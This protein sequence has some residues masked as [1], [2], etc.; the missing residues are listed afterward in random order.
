METVRTEPMVAV[1]PVGH[2]L[3]HRR[4]L[5]MDDLAGETLPRR[6]DERD[7][8][9][10]PVV[11]DA[12]QLLE[13]VALGQAVALLPA[14][15]RRNRRPDLAYALVR[16]APMTTLVVAWPEVSTS[17]AMAG[18]C[19]PRQAPPK[20]RRRT[21]GRRESPVLAVLWSGRSIREADLCCKPVI[22]TAVG[23]T[24]HDK[25]RPFHRAAYLAF[26]EAIW[27]RLPHV[28]SNTAVLTTPM[29]AGG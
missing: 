5:T 22:E 18:S 8:I 28:S 9:A 12:A 15:V 25:M 24:T 23:I 14:S 21:S 26:S 29:S 27:I 11:R 2:R 7:P 13:T 19:G 10:A 3:A 6:P 4:E 17:G 16:D 20:R 1:L